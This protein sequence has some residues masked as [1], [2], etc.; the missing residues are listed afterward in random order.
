MSQSYGKKN[1]QNLKLLVIMGRTIKAMGRVIVPR[2]RTTGL[3]QTQFEVPEALYHKGP[4]TIQEI[5]ETIFSTSGNITVVVENLVKADFVTKKTGEDD[6][7]KRWVS[8]TPPG[9]KIIRDFFPGHLE[10]LDQVFSGLDSNEKKQLT[11]LL[12]KLGKNI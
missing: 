5:I 11:V 12:K 4:M 2:F 8:I 10:D 1:N 7:R 6:R 3:T 9:E